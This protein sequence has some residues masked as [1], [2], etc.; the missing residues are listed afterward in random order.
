MA[1]SIPAYR[2]RAPIPIAA[3]VTGPGAITPER[4][5]IT[6]SNKKRGKLI[7]SPDIN[8]INAGMP[9]AYQQ[10]GEKTIFSCSCP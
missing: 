6:T 7:K 1:I 5:I 10:S 4:D 2:E 8:S 9:L 3:A